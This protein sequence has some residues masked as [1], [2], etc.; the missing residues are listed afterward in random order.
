M[1]K[2]RHPQY[3]ISVD[4]A[5]NL[6]EIWSIER[7][8][9]EPKG[10]LLELRENMKKSIS[11]IISKKQYILH[12]S[13]HSIIRERCDL[14]NILFYNIGASCFSEIVREGIRFERLFANAP[15][16][17]GTEEFPHY[18]KYQLQKKQGGF[19]YWKRGVPS[20]HFQS[21][22]IPKLKP[23]IIWHA[24]LTQSEMKVDK[25]LKKRDKFG[26]SITLAIPNRMNTNAVSVVKPLFDGV[27][28]SFHQ[29]NGMDIDEI[30][31]RLS[32]KLDGDSNELKVLL[33]NDAANLLGRRRLLWLRG[34]GVQ[35]NPRDDDCVA[36]E[37]LIRKAKGND[38]HIS[39]HIFKCD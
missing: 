37:L 10:W 22:T 31:N 36:G 17:E 16:F 3:S 34:Q 27:I 33:R 9:F 19:L 2:I 21:I 35:W 24:M 20:Y 38:Y 11:Q 29:H 25:S 6:V 18:L 26:L 15:A 7:I 1:P 5:K 4:Q 32:M 30:S 8:P 12:A 39:G 28:A 14:E 23:E 13:Y